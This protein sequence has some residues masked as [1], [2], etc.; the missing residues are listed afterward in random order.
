MKIYEYKDYDE[1]V[2]IQTSINKEKEGWVYVKESTIR[3][4]C[5]YQKKAKNI[6]CHGT[7]SGAE[8]KMFLNHFPDSYVIGTE[9]SDTASKYPM[10]IQHDFS[11]VK[12]EW[13]GKFDI[14]Y[15]N[16]FDHTICPEET[17]KVWADQLSE[18]G[19]IYLEYAEK[20]S[21][22]IPADPL[23][24]TL[25]EIE[26]MIV[27]SGLKIEKRLTDGVKHAGTILIFKR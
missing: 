25:K 2:K 7:R 24:A 8:Q 5:G 17:I 23:E 4:I 19:R 15:S 22:C 12:D 16:S 9:I 3:D 26:N 27:E 1:Y 18:E 20:Q 10:T 21:I 14:V 13:V 11:K 6:L